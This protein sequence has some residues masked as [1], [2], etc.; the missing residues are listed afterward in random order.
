MADFCCRKNVNQEA[1]DKH[2]KTNLLELYLEDIYR[3]KLV[4]NEN[5]ITHKVSNS[6]DRRQRVRAWI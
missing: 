6:N 2:E 3:K 5:T 4:Q 1:V